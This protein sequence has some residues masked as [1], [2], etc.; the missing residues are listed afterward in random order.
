[1]TRLKGKINE[2]VSEEQFGFRKGKGTTNAI[3]TLKIILERSIEMQKECFYV[4]CG[5]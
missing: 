5:V 4:F 1:M 3:F 2:R